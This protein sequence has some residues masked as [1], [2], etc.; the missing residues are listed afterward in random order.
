MI[1]KLLYSPD[2]GLCGGCSFHAAATSEIGDPNQRLLSLAFPRRR[3]SGVFSDETK[4][5]RCRRVACRFFPTYSPT[6]FHFQ[7]RTQHPRLPVGHV[8]EQFPGFCSNHTAYLIDER[9]ES[10]ASYR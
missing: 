7:S 10:P 5:M 9:I 6:E 2:A 8:S 4:N 3:S 1:R